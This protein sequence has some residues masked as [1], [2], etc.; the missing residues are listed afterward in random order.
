V[1]NALAKHSA[2][3]RAAVVLITDGQI[4]NEAAIFEALRPHGGV[5]VHTFGI[6]TTVNDALLTRV[7]EQQRGSC[8]L[9]MPTD[10][11]AGA[12]ARLGAR[13]RRPVLTGISVEGDWE[14]PGDAPGD[15]HSEEVALLSLKG[16]AGASEVT[17]RGRRSDGVEQTFRVKLE[18][19]PEP[20]LKLL[21]ARDAI[22]HRQRIGEKSEALE[23][24]TRFN[25][26]CEGA[27]FVAW[28]EAEKVSIATREVYQLCLENLSGMLCGTL[29]MDS[30][31]GRGRRL[32]ETQAMYLHHGYASPPSFQNPGPL[33]RGLHSTPAAKREAAALLDVVLKSRPPDVQ[34]FVKARGLFRLRTNPLFVRSTRWVMGMSDTEALGDLQAGALFAL[35]FEWAVESVA[36]AESRIEK[37]ESLLR[38]ME[39]CAPDCETGLAVIRVWAEAEMSEAPE[40]LKRTL[41]LLN[42][43]ARNAQCVPSFAEVPGVDDSPGLNP[44]T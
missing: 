15:L 2:G 30:H 32:D 39:H 36:D 44:Q 29:S 28:D 13:L 10:D 4:G 8:C 43:Y 9:L 1:L 40:L 21:W 12:V 5:R 3:R 6:D 26:L 35:L 23:L 20:A 34:A 24:A 31:V 16:K 18:P 27:A 33:R 37:L 19:R 7:A 22:S 42:T 25:L 41:D 17:L 38:Q 11:I 14:L